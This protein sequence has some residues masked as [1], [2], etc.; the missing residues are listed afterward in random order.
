MKKYLQ[1]TSVQKSVGLVDFPISGEGP[2][3]LTDTKGLRAHERIKHRQVIIAAAPGL[4]GLVG[5]TSALVSCSSE[6]EAGTA[7]SA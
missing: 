1:R 3:L 5:C 7:F 4:K 2:A 6:A